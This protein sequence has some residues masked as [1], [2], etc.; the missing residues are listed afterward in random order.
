MVLSP[1]PHCPVVPVKGLLEPAKSGVDL[2]HGVSGWPGVLALVSSFRLVGHGYQVRHVAKVGCH[3]LW[4]LS[5]FRARF[6]D[7]ILASV[8]KVLASWFGG[9]RLLGRF[10]YSLDERWRDFK[11]IFLPRSILLLYI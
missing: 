11:F 6:P 9:D 7:S 10:A 3:Y 5:C 4:R 8:E 1:F 2:H